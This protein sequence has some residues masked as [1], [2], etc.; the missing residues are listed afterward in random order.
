MSTS[1]CTLTERW[2]VGI[3]RLPNL[4]NCNGKKSNLLGPW[5]DIR[6]QEN[7]D[8]GRKFKIHIQSISYLVHAAVMGT[9]DQTCHSVKQLLKVLPVPEPSL[10]E[11]DSCIVNTN[12]KPIRSR[13][14]QW[15]YLLQNFWSWY[16]HSHS[17]AGQPH[18]L[19]EP[20][21][22]RSARKPPRTAHSS[23]AHILAF[24]CSQGDESLNQEI[25]SETEGCIKIA[26]NLK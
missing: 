17:S 23:A 7:H 3:T 24:Y 16:S 15:S 20:S 4:C 1:S 10:P 21:V 25:T 26:C 14:T 8:T 22:L 18:G 2:L 13:K 9:R 12:K 19:T 5:T 6:A 11:T